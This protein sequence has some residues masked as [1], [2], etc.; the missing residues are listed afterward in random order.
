MTWNQMRNE[1]EA[2]I[3]ERA[4][5]LIE[6]GLPER[7][8]WQ[9]ARREF[10][11]TTLTI[12][13]SREVWGWTWLENLGRDLR[14][15]F[16]AM[17]ANR[18]FTALAVASLA[19]GIGANTAIYSFMESILLRSL[20]VKDPQSL[21]V[22]KFVRPTGPTS[23]DKG[24][25]N[26]HITSGGSYDGMLSAFPFPAFE[27]FEKRTDLFDGTFAY[28]GQPEARITLNGGSMLGDT[29]YVSGAYFSTLGTKAAL[30]RTLQSEDEQ[31]GAPPVADISVGLA[32]QWFGDEQQALGKTVGVNGVN[33]TIVG[34]TPRD[35]F[36]A[37]PERS[38]LV[39]LPL[40]SY[41][42]TQ[43]LRYTENG[44]IFAESTTYWLDVMVRL[45]P[46]VTRERAQAAL[47]PAF[48]EYFRESSGDTPQKARMLVMDGARG[49]DSLRHDY[50]QPLYVLMAMVGLI[51]TI[52]CVN[53]ANLL[54]SRASSRKRELAVRLSLGASRG[55]VI[56][57]LLTESL[58][59]SLMGALLG[60]LFAKWGVQ[61][62]TALLAMGRQD[63][64]LRAELNWPVL[65]AT[66]LVSLISGA[67]FGLAPALR[68][69]KLD[70][71]DSLRA[72]QASPGNPKRRWM[73]IHLGQ[74]LIV[75]QIALSFLL[76]MG[77]GLFVRT[78]SKLQSIELGFNPSHLLL[79]EVNTQQAGYQ[80]A[81]A[82][83][84]HEQ[85]RQKFARIPGV[86]NATLA[87]EGQL[88][89]GNWMLQFTVP[90]SLSEEKKST[91]MLPVGPGYLATLQIP[92]LAGRDIREDDQTRTWTA[93]VVSET[94]ARK[95]FGSVSSAPGHHVSM[96][97]MDEEDIEIVGVAK[98]ARYVNLKAPMAAMLYVDYRHDPGFSNGAT[99]VVIRFAGEPAATTSAARQILREA[100]PAVPMG[101]IYSQQDE[102]DSTLIQ[103]I[104]FARLC[105]AFAG[106]ALIIACV[107]LYGTTAYNVSRRT[108]EIGV[109][110]ALGAQR[111]TVLAMVL[112]EVAVLG[113]AGLAIGLPIALGMSRLVES[114]LYKVQ[115]R[116]PVTIAIAIVVMLVGALLAAFVPAQRAA[117]VDPMTA[118]RHE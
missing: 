99:R 1:V 67:A 14:Y 76:L 100:D 54:L 13:R 73:P 22:L 50:A 51:L 16:R 116:D 72:S 26:A 85:L 106:L 83:A 15:A 47:N 18:L 81:P 102:I 80:H 20:P 105:A 10:G 117:R 110:M 38:S 43:P 3:E 115:P 24:K 5:D 57:H 59:L 92:L 101:M 37:N 69:T 49:L 109:R 41:V 107:G 64:T 30:G 65:A 66:A 28:H 91:L 84:F 78:L 98:D 40:H 36:G 48:A 58:A 108:S 56:R 103:E 53:I 62:L 88:D 44:K 29:D 89:G 79:F 2:H 19:L 31:P 95:H 93:A 7:E 11:N 77:A 104:L 82:I 46:S 112:R 70:V 90:G 74:A 68:S 75:A 25:L 35:F 17:A 86:T 4:L 61:T 34:I 42:L 118:L 63:F 52:A 32:R 87:E 23:K 12:E 114:F 6:S 60:L 45:K 8:A 9:Q 71:F 94:F 33:F 97:F 39:Y 96:K 27:L 111:K 55:R 113:I 21:A